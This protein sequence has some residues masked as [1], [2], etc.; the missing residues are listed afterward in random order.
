MVLPLRSNPADLRTV[1]PTDVPLGLYIHLPWCIKK[2]PYCDFNSHES[3]GQAPL[4]T[5]IDSVALDLEQALPMVWGRAV[6][7]VFIG[8]G[9]PNLLTAAQL[10]RLLTSVR[11]RLPIESGAEITMEAN[12]GATEPL[13]FQGYRECGVN[14]LSIGVQTFDSA[15]LHRIGRVHDSREA[16]AAVESA[17]SIFERVNVDLMYGLPNQTLQAALD[18][19]G[20]AIRSGV[21]H[22]SHYQLTMEPNTV[23]ANRP[24]SGLPDEEMIEAIESEGRGLLADAGFARYEV[25][26]F[27]RKG[28]PC[29]HNL[30]YWQF[31]DYLGLGA[32]AHSKLSLPLE[33]IFRHNNTRRPEDYM[34]LVGEGKGMH[35]RIELVSTERLGFEFMLN[36]LRLTAGFEASLFEARTGRPLA[37]VLDGVSVAER[38]GLLQ[39]DRGGWVPTALGL[40]FLNDL[41]MLFMH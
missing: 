9:T 8:G 29:R 17:V 27:A 21:G 3:R 38:R 16:E 10:D 19:L 7:F 32:G 14:R 24:P 30:N 20:R 6:K 26:A 5:Y 4:D 36:A 41:Q 2:C 22:I 35:R 31:G 23:F 39:R 37:E 12:P 11:A 1:G 18:D 13:A 28:Q 15:A 34:R 40:R 33:G 25:S